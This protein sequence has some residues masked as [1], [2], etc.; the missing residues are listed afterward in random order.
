MPSRPLLTFLLAFCLL[1]ASA[2]SNKILQLKDFILED[3]NGKPYNLSNLKGKIV[4]VDC[5][6]PACAPC[7]GEMPWEDLL[8]RRTKQLGL[9]TSVVFVTIC[10]KQNRKEWLDALKNIPVPGSVHLYAA[11][12]K[13][14]KDLVIDESFPTYRI[15]N[16]KGELDKADCPVPSE[17]GQVDFI[18]FAQSRNTG[19]KNAVK[20]VKSNTNLSAIQH[21]LWKE[22]WKNFEPHA[23]TFFTEANKLSSGK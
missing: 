4:Y 22:F 7:R 1:T 14:M 5:W 12:G 21:P 17:T 13:Y 19:I 18:L 23:Q 9:D 16:K 15:F 20:I 10:F 3:V 8:I 2:Q 11:N 6:F